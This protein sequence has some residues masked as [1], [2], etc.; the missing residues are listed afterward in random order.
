MS[1]GIIGSGTLGS[2]IARMFARRGISA[3]ITN[4]RGPA[5][6]APLLDLGTLDAGGPLA[7]LPFGPLATAS[8]IQ[9]QI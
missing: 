1:I 5:S 7:S 6:L 8:L 2:N 4:R 9:I 3:T